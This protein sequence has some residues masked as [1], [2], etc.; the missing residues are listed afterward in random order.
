MITSNVTNIKGYK[1]SPLGLPPCASVAPNEPCVNPIFSWLRAIWAYPQTAH[2]LSGPTK[3]LSP[4][5]INAYDIHSPTP[6]RQPFHIWLIGLPEW[7][8][9]LFLLLFDWTI[10]DL[11]VTSFKTRWC[12]KGC[13]PWAS[14][15]GVGS[16]MP[17]P[18]GKGKLRHLRRCSKGGPLS[19][20][21][22]VVCNDGW[23]SVV[24]NAYW[25]N[26]GWWFLVVH[27]DGD[28]VWWRWLMLDDHGL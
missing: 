11:L 2:R 4:L 17:Q 8:V 15:R 28:H 9:V 10:H 6:S 5:G 19:C 25:L 12:S 1:P 13:Q 20:F 22:M 26:D 27:G 16:V 3:S 24:N 7:A 14:T 21:R 18:H 23:R